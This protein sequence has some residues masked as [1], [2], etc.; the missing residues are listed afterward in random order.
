MIR[1]NFATRSP[2]NGFFVICVSRR[3]AFMHI[4]PARRV[5]NVRRSF[6]R[7]ILKATASPD[8]I[9]F[10]GGLP[11]PEFIPVREIGQA[12]QHVLSR[13]G[14][15]AL[16]YTVTEGYPPLR[17][18]VADHYARFGL[19]VSPDQ[20]IITAGSQ[21]GLDLLGKVLI[22]PGDRVI[23]EDPT[24][25]AAIQA[26]GMYEPQLLPVPLDEHGIEPHEL[27]RA[28]APG[29]R[30]VYTMPNF[31]NPSGTSYS[32]MRREEV[33][34]ILRNTSAVLVEDDPY[35]LLRFRGEFLPP[36]ALQRP[37]R[38]VLLGSFSK[39]VAPG[40]RLGWI[41]APPELIDRLVIAKQSVDLHS[42][43]L[44]QRVIHQLV[45][46]A[47]FEQHLQQIRDAYRRQCDAMLNAIA[48][49]LPPEVRSTRPDGG[50]FLWVSLPQEVSTVTL[51]D[52]ALK[53]GVAFVPGQAFHVSGKGENTM[54]LNFSNSDE[55]RIEE[56]VRR[57]AKAMRSLR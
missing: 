25:L 2:W 54:R 6:V 32:R 37:D 29:A 7:E 56:G 23:V 46:S 22:D 45:S 24:Y 39:I 51:F 9:S 26:F 44:G 55:P 3:K 8:V 50:M 19:K 33:A 4:Q 41:C 34:E 52:H 20:I 35:G 53:Q 10:A 13:D 48:Q 42:E 18:W 15:A 31:Q 17:E 14:A 21:Q 47:H 27:R 43:N 1:L 11:S 40:M 38:S 49:H 16:Q 28:I 30:L 57:L 5:Q 12:V 36:M